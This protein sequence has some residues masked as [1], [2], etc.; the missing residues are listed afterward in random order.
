MNK[1]P[2]AE[3]IK[4][5]EPEKKERAYAWQTAI[6]LQ[7]VDGLETS[8]YLAE[9]AARNIEGDISIDEACELL[10]KYYAESMGKDDGSRT[11]EADKVSARIAKILSQ[12]AFSF[13]PN[14]YTSLHGKLFMGIYD[15]AGKI[16]DYN[17][18]KKEW[19]LDGA[20]VTYGTASE[21][22]ATLEYDLSKEKKFSYKGLTMDEVIRH[23]ATFV[24]GLW[25][26]HAFAEGNT[27]TTA[28]FFI[29]YLQSLGFDVTNEP[30]AKNAWYFRNAL[31]RANYN[32]IKNGVHAT[33]E[34]LELFLR[35]LLLGEENPLQNRQMHI[36]NLLK[37][38]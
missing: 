29:K 36:S 6:G 34:F 13:T 9:T 19:I 17:I 8:E 21:L 37:Q 4:E 22:V 11:G 10:D 18:T 30:F 26:I 31:V 3:Y 38:A 20:T 27:R 15:H 33:T 16:R 24:S 1:D 14:E 12:K 5:S 23:L 2:F 35:N 28:V 25:Q 7:D 32:D